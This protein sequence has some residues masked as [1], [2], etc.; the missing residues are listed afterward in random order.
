MADH[1]LDRPIWNSLTTSHAPFS[2]G[3]GGAR[4][5]TENVS[6]FAAV[7]DEREESLAALARLVPEEGN[8][9]LIQV[10][11]VVLPEGINAAMA[12]EGEQM[13][14]ESLKSSDKMPI[15]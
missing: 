15:G 10:P 3:G 2:M 8:L 5:F 13:V 7:K 14:L 6:I 9:F 4:R 11:P 1:I 12:G